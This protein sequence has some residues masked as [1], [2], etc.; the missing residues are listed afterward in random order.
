MTLDLQTNKIGSQGAM[1]LADALQ[2]N[3]VSSVLIRIALLVT[4]EHRQSQPLICNVIKL[5]M[6]AQNIWVMHYNIIE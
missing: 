4:T 1:Y 2:N 3:T 6:K 5:V